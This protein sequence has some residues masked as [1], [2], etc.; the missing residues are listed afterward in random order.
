MNN[1]RK[2]F[3]LIACYLLAA[4]VL[5]FFAARIAKKSAPPAAAEPDSTP[6]TDATLEATIQ[7]SH[8]EYD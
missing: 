6:D 1:W 5:F 3:A 7:S 2:T 8:S 4:S